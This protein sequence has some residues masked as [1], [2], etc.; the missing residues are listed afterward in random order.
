MFDDPQPFA[1]GLNA[2]LDAVERLGESNSA[3]ES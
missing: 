2:I 3:A 1:V